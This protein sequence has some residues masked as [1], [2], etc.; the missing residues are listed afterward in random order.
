MNGMSLFGPDS[1]FMAQVGKTGDSNSVE[2]GAFR[3]D[4]R[5]KVSDAHFAGIQ[6]EWLSAPSGGYRY[7]TYTSGTVSGRS[8]FLDDAFGFSG[9]TAA[10]CWNAFWP[11]NWRSRL[12][13][14]YE[15][16][17]YLNRPVLDPV[18][19]MPTG[20]QRR[21]H[22]RWA[23][24]ELER[25]FYPGLRGRDLTLTA[26]AFLRGFNRSSSDPYY[27]GSGSVIGAS[28]RLGW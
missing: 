4:L 10:A 18:M 1:Q 13:V 27:V 22:I 25:A 21:D 28:L 9:A 6:A 23:S 26:Q 19:G 5:M 24:L 8:E 2:H 7:S 12:S 3:A 11:K 17:N 20:Q 16:R 14:S 15:E